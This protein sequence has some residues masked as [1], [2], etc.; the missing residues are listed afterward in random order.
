MAVIQKSPAR[1]FVLIWTGITMIVG[2]ATFVGIYLAYDAENSDLFG[3]NSVDIPIIATNTPEAVAQ[4]ST[5]T[6]TVAPT[7]IRLQIHLFQPIHRNPKYL[8]L[9][10]M[11]S[12]PSHR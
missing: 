2:I 6:A 9:K 7:D 12:K 11:M 1:G 10:K 8:K 3:Q 5:N 4:A